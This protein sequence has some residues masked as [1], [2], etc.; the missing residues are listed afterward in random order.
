MAKFF[1][2]DKP[3]ESTGSGNDNS[4]FNQSYIKELAKVI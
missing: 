4:K 3:R 1:G 2:L